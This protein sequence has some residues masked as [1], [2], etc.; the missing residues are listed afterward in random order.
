MIRGTAVEL[1]RQSKLG[2]WL[3]ARQT[4]KARRSEPEARREKKSG[5]NR[6]QDKEYSN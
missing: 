4:E 3:A 6:K 1:G 5:T 2:R